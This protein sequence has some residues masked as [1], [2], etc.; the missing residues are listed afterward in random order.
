MPEVAAEI[1]ATLDPAPARFLPGDTVAVRFALDSAMDQTVP[2]DL[3]G[4]AQFVMIGTLRVLGK[5][6]EQLRQELKNAYAGKLSSTDLSVNMGGPGLDESAAAT[7]RTVHILGEVRSPGSFPILGRRITLLEGL[8][9]A[10]SFDK[11]TALLKQVLLVRWMPEDGTY[12]AWEIDARTK[13]WDSP[14]QIYLQTHDVVFVPQTP[15]DVVN[16]WV[17]QYIRQMI[18]FPYLMLPAPATTP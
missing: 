14:N 5:S 7:F 4:N 13:H 11:R 18:P 17:D 8:A 3:E 2:V 9:R 12:R 15:I 6:P 16:I 10:G 1:N